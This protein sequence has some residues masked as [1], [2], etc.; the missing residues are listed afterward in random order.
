MK[1]Q[2][3]FNTQLIRCIVC[4]FHFKLHVLKPFKPNEPNLNLTITW[5]A[6]QPDQLPSPLGSYNTSTPLAKHY[7][8]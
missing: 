7:P 1:K 8:S 4:L 5:K 6:S 3:K 2:Q